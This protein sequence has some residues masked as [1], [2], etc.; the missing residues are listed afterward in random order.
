MFAKQFWF[1]NITKMRP[2]FAIK[3][4]CEVDFNGAINFYACHPHA[5]IQKL[6]NTKR[7]IQCSQLATYVKDRKKEYEKNPDN[8]RWGQI[9]TLAQNTIKV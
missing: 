7:C 8:C 3:G 9:P 5:T 6:K 4:Y 2:P 1:E